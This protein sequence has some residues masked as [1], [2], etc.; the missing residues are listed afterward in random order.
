M[1]IT[2]MKLHSITRCATLAFLWVTMPPAS[3]TDAD[4]LWYDKP[5]SHWLEAL[6]VG[7]GR[8]GAM[9][10]GGVPEER[11]QFNEQ[12]LWTGTNRSQGWL[13]KDKRNEGTRDGAMG[14]YQPFGDV[15]LRF[16]K[17]HQEKT[18]YRRELDLSTG[19]TTTTYQVGEVVFTREVFASHPGRVV[20]M[21]L[22]SNIPGALT[23]QVALQDAK[24]P[25]LPPAPTT[26]TSSQLEFSGKLSR[27]ARVP[28]NEL[29]WND[30]AY[31]ATLRVL[32]E[33]GTVKTTKD[34]LSISQANS[35]TLLLAAATDYIASPAKNYRGEAPGPKIKAALD[36]AAK[37]SFTQLRDA[38]LADHQALFDRV[39]LRLA[40]TPASSL[41]TDQ[42]LAVYQKGGADPALEALLF[43]FGRYL[44]IA[45]SRPGG[46]PAN[47]QGV[48]NDKPKPAWY[49]GYTTNINVEMNYWPA[50]TT[51]LAECH[52]PLF[53]W[54]D[55]LAAAQK[56]NPDPKLRTPLGWIIYSTNNP[57]GGNSGWAFHLPGSAWLSQHFYE[58]WAFGGDRE[59]L[60][61]RA[62]PHLRE[63]TRMW[64]ARLVDGPDGT[65]ITPDGWSP[66]HGPVKMPDGKIVIKEG[67]RTPQPGASYDQQIIWDLFSNFI[68]ASAALDRDPELRQRITE[69]RTRLLGPKVGRFGQLQEW[70]ED[71]DDMHN[72]YRHISHLFALHPGR[73]ISPVTTP[74]FAKAAKVT[75]DSRSDKSCGWSRAWKITFRARLHDGNHAGKVVRSML[76]YVPA[77][78]TGSGT[79]PNL[80]GAGPPFQ[81]DSNFGYTAGV[82]EMLL[83]SHLRTEDGRREIHLLPAI[84]DSWASGEANGLRARDGFTIDQKWEN[85]KLV[86]ATI[87]SKLGRPLRIRY[88]DKTYDFEVPAGSSKTFVP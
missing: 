64:D 26:V 39:S 61:K 72:D 88:Q 17:E 44:L 75:L 46:L 67:D 24:R 60:A 47:L 13:D 70:K 30:M 41:P 68:D 63:L 21:R 11:I 1:S 16:P 62:Y 57:L 29:R 27:P 66:E 23:F 15:F 51:N 54:L 58:G 43:Q 18:A 42:R 85:G 2:P 35:V 69:R 22:T 49:S 65:L 7:N 73:Q 34:G 80:F 40:T 25:P 12:S 83:Q 4:L 77:N 9:I 59:F 87:T 37:Q 48:W 50:E 20:V 38:H 81:I 71:V 31:H 53:D 56:L 84:P 36:A 45:S 55:N 86:S 74:D 14:D 8:M 78:K 32:P 10:F 19:I 28:K 82:A 76:E 3:G 79:Y 52:Q 6:P 33:G 5:A